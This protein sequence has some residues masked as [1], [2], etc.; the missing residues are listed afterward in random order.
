MVRKWSGKHSGEWIEE[1]RR[2]RGVVVE[3]SGVECTV[4]NSEW[5]VDG[6]ERRE[7]GQVECRPQ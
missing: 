3:L 1:W 4:E 7:L 6:G 2:E 5:N